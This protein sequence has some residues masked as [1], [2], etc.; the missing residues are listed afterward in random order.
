MK[1]RPSKIKT[2]THIHISKDEI[3]Y[4]LSYL[5]Y[6][7]HCHFSMKTQFLF[8]KKKHQ[9]KKPLKNLRRNLSSMKKECDINKQHIYIS[10]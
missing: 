7:C 8:C 2:R 3:L 10:M 5:C 1:K 9:I 4:N 6:G